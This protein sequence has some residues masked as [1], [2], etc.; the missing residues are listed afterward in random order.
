MLLQ[1]TLFRTYNISIAL[2]DAL[3]ANTADLTTNTWKASR[4][5]QRGAVFLAGYAE[6]RLAISHSPP[7]LLKFVV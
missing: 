7:Y 6:V 1:S 2:D 5:V 3:G 4:C